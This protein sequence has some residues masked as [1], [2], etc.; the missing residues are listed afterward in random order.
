MGVTHFILMDSSKLKYY[1]D[2]SQLRGMYGNVAVVTSYG[3]DRWVN[4]NL[5]MV[6]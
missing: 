5:V 1:V 3:G 4:F 2:E 6:F